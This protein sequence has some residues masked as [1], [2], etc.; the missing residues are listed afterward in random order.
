[1]K[2]IIAVDQG[3]TSS[4][5]ILF[6]EHCDIVATHQMEISLSYPK[7]GWVEQNAL[8]IWETVLA[9]CEEVIQ[10]TR[11]NPKDIASIGITNQ[12]ETTILWDKLTGEPVYPAIVWQSRQ[13]KDI[14][15]DLIKQ[16]YAEMIQEKTGLIINPYFSASKIKF[17]FDHNPIIKERAQKGEIL[18][19]TVDTFILWK[20]TEGKVHATD[21]SNASRTLLFNINTLTW[22]DEL[23]ALFDIPSAMLPQVFESSHY[24]GDATAL[25]K[26]CGDDII[27]INSLIGDQQASLFGQCCFNEGD[28]KSTYGTGCFMLMNTKQK[29]IK[30]ANGLITTIAWGLDGSVEYAL[31]GSVFVGG[32]AVQWL[33]DGM[34]LIDQ[35]KD[36]ERY[37]DRIASSEGVY[38][39]PAFVGLGAPYWDDDAKGSVFGLTRATKREH[40]INALVESIAYQTKDVMEVMVQDSKTV[41]KNLAVDGGASTNNYLMQ[42]QADILNCAV[43]RPKVFE[44]TAKGAAYLAGLN[45]KLWQSKRELQ[46]L[47]TVDR[48]FMP[49]IN[50]AKREQLYFGW[51]KAVEATRVFKTNE[52]LK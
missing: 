16:G 41:I 24:F 38:F 39:V 3:T 12:R 20:L 44:S 18:F 10:R 51:K 45:V 49:K 21:Y 23:L 43:V 28:V 14:C 47:K 2:Y 19:G 5:A 9:V 52:G 30:S 50:E 4:R 1:M 33:R 15:D 37:S 22:D 11:I 26:V 32:S 31:E 7:S 34:R 17:I 48:I 8:E 40:F 25:R 36:V 29:I 42:F 6:D 27:P 13:S 46:N 35:S